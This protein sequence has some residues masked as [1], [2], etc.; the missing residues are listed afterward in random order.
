MTHSEILMLWYKVSW[1][2]WGVPGPGAVWTSAHNTAGGPTPLFTTT[3][4]QAGLRWE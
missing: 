4:L 2:G 3:Y 1:A